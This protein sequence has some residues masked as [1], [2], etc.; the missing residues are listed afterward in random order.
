MSGG[1]AERTGLQNRVGIQSEPRSAQSHL[2][3]PE[4]RFVRP[5]RPQVGKDGPLAA[6]KLDQPSPWDRRR[7]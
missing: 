6:S 3:R 7:S 2:D 4:R 1:L 5:K